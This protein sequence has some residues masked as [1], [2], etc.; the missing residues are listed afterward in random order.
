MF[1][2]LVAPLLTRQVRSV[3]EFGCGTAALSRR[4]AQAAPWADVYAADKSEGM[5][6][7]AQN[8]AE[9]AGLPNLHL[10]PWDVLDKDAYPFPTPRFDLIISSVV[11]PYFSDDQAVGLIDRLVKRLAPG[12]VLA[13]LEQD[14]LSDSLTF[15]SFEL[16]QKI[17]GKDRRAFKRSLG[18]GLRP[19][20]RAAGLT[21]LPRQSFLWTDDAYGPY[22]RDLLERFADSAC[23]QGYIQ[24]EER[25]MWKQT[26]NQLAADGDFYYSIVYHRV[27]GRRE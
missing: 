13:F 17:V 9:Q 22:T 16:F 20:L 26:L 5:L 6:R 18:L 4:M 12:G 19:M 2:H 7:V 21:L 25:D 24:V 14:W 10:Y 3:C 15:P 11:I 27:A 8:L 23:E 1:T